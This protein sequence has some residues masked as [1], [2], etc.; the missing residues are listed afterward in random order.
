MALL[1]AVIG[2]RVTERGSDMQQMVPRPLIK[3]QAAA[4]RTKPLHMGRL[5][6]QLS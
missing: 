1:T 4:A 5:L 6:Y 3:P 2:N